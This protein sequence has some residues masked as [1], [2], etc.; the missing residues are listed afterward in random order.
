MAC[1]LCIV[2]TNVGGIPD[3]LKDGHTALLVPPN[4]A[5]SMSAAVTSMISEQG[6][7]SKISRNARTT[8]EQFDWSQVL[9]RWESLFQTLTGNE[10]KETDWKLSNVTFSK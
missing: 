2:S 8:A 6:L 3:L 9:P 10:Q 4:D 5:E 1:G 7:A